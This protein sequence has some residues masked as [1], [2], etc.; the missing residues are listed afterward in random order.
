MAAIAAG[1]GVSVETIY[2]SIGNKPAVLKAVLDVAIVGDDDDVPM[3]ARPL[4]AQL[5]AEPDPRKVFAR[6]GQ[7]VRI[8]A[9]AS[10]SAAP[11]PNR[12]HRGRRRATPLAGRPGRTVDRHD[13]FRERSRATGLPPTRRGRREAR[14]ILWTLTAPEQYEVLVVQRGWAIERVDAFITDAMIGTLLPPNA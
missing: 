1:A 12:C 14:D 9:T 6:Y 3:L 10:A 2:K 7:H 11:A 13:G 8:M 5:R 4:V